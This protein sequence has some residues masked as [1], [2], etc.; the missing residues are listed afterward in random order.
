[1]FRSDRSMEHMHGARISPSPTKQVLFPRRP[2]CSISHLL[3]DETNVSDLPREIEC[4]CIVCLGNSKFGKN[5]CT[6]VID[7]RPRWTRTTP[8]KYVERRLRCKNCGK[9][10]R[11]L[12]INT[13]L[14]S[15]PDATIQA[16]Y[17]CS[18]GLSQCDQL[19]MLQ[20]I[21]SAARNHRWQVPK[22]Q[23]RDL[24][25]LYFESR[26]DTTVHKMCSKC[27]R[28]EIEMEPRWLKGT[29]ICYARET[30]SCSTPGCKGS[31]CNVIPV[32]ASIKYIK[33][34][35]LIARLREDRNLPLDSNNT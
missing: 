33:Y 35:D 29:D 18:Q 14:E 30:R 24:M 23:Y 2:K 17:R 34:R 11:C 31:R 10:R 28:R 5:N 13:S 25:P 19:L 1:V 6:V 26:E 15:L 7:Q 3:K 12:P 20:R 27:S 21:P 4:T 9:A 32:D 22:G 16:F 8:P